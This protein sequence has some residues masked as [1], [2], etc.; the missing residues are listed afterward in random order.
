MWVNALG[1]LIVFPVLHNGSLLIMDSQYTCVYMLMPNF[2]IMLAS[3]FHPC[4]LSFFVVVVAPS[5]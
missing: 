1:L 5:L 2:R 4:G 3:M